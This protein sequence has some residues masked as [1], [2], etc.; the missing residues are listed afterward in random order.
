MA[1]NADRLKLYWS[2]GEGAAKIRWGT[3]GDFDRC[4][5]LVT[6]ETGGKGLNV[7]GYCNERHHEALGFYPATHAKM[8]KHAA[9][10]DG[11]QP[12]A[13]PSL[14]T[15]PG[16]D[17]LAAGSWNLLSGE[18][19]FSTDDLRNAIQAA[20]C[21]S[22]GDPVI[23]IGHNDPNFDGEPAVGRV[24]NMRLAAQG[25]KVTA[26]L[27]GM[28]GWLGAVAASAYPRRSIEG[29][30]N[31]ACQTGH[32]HPFV[33]TA[34]ALLGVTPPG[35]G[36]LSGLPNVAAL[37][38]VTAAAQVPRAELWITAGGNMPEITAAAISEADVRRAYY[39]RE[40]LPATYWITE[41]RMDPAELIVA[42]EATSKVYRVPWSIEAGAVAFGD[43]REVQVTYADVM[44]SLGR[45][46]GTA[47]TFASAADSRDLPQV[48]A[49]DAGDGG[50]QDGGQAGGDGTAGPD[51]DG[52]DASWDGDLAD[53]GD[54][55][56]LTV[57]DIV[58]AA[59][60]LGDEVADDDMA[61]GKPKLGSGARAAKLKAQ[62]LSG[63]LIG[64]IGR[65]RYGAKRMA[66]WA[67]QGRKRKAAH[68]AAGGVS[69]DAAGR[70]GAWTGTHSHPHAALGHQGGDQTH[71]HSHSHKGDGTHAHVHAAGRT[72]GG[73]EVEFTEAQQAALRSALGM[74]EDDELTEDSLVTAAGALRERAD[75]K[76]MA[77]GRPA[78][79]PPGVMTV[80]KQAW[81]SLNS[82]IQ[83]AKAFRSEVARGERDKIIAAAVT[84]G[85]FAPA[86]VR[87]YEK[88]WDADPDN[89]RAVIASLPRNAVPVEDVG[90]AGTE[91]DLTPD[92]YK[93][94]F[95][96]DYQ[97]A[98]P[99]G[100]MGGP[101]GR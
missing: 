28:P 24:R 68:A 77:A 58:D 87:L 59:R 23:K 73:T 41:L 63:A 84:Q 5:R 70:H 8:E 35:V 97:R 18:Q 61:A 94:L 88:M 51:A 37:Y 25:T 31:F 22:V 83:A 17:I 82:E 47:I 44:A 14:I 72:G 12:V 29:T 10:A 21:P 99:N 67:A 50:G 32:R 78:P 60:S 98:A 66:K 7:K 95:P 62:G 76:V 13:V 34:L 86:R 69:V 92:E 40:G 2:H 11:P 45:A 80:D 42:D 74:A 93:S 36:V 53:L 52:L 56:G 90:A 46:S 43:A 71:D 33:I 26:D 38:G 55:S 81:E 39:D 79:L 9:A 3:P 1:G 75:A 57:A 16:V 20:Q 48:T 89:A 54:M 15:I 101:A 30:Y 85:K 27:V 49:A 64:W 4:V 19:E 96:P 65:H 6:E 100:V 91:D